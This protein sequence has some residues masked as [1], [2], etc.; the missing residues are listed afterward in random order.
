VATTGLEVAAGVQD[1]VE[2]WIGKLYIHMAVSGVNAEAETRLGGILRLDRMA[3]I[4]P[5][6]EARLV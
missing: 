6:L 4:V 2:A 3:C 1:G 5:R